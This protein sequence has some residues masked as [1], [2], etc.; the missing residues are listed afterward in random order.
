MKNQILLLA[1][2]I[3]TGTGFYGKSA[4]GQANTNLS[5]L[6]ATTSVN[7]NLLPQTNNTK[8]LGSTAYSWMNVY[9]DGTIF[10]GDAPFIT[11]IGS[12]NSL[13][14]N[15]AG[16]SITTG[17]FNTFTGDNAGRYTNT[18]YSNSFFGNYAG[19]SN[20]A[21]Y[22]NTFVGKSAGYLNNASFNTGV[23]ASALLNNTTG[24]NNAAVGFN[25]LASNTT[26]HKNTAMG[27]LALENNQQGDAN[28]A[29]GYSALEN[30]TWGFDN[31]AVGGHTLQNQVFAYGN[32]A[33]GYYALQWLEDGNGNTAIGSHAMVYTAS[34]AGCT[35]IGSYALATSDGN[36][37]TAIGTNA[38]DFDQTGFANTALGSGADVTGISLSNA[39]A[40]GYSAQVDASNKV[41]IGNSSVT[42]NGG[43]VSW[44]AYSDGRIKSSIQENV[45]GLQFINQLRPVTYHFDLN[46]QNELLGLKDTTQW[47]GKYDI[48]KIQ[49]TGFIAQEV[50]AAANKI[51]YD[52]SGVD[53]SGEIMG[54]RYA[55]FVVPLVKSV[56][57]LSEQNSILQT[58][59]TN[60]ETR[61]AKLEALLS[62]INT[63]TFQDA[64]GQSVKIL[65]QDFSL[66]QNIPNPYTGKTSINYFVPENAKQA[67]IVFATQGGIEVYSTDI[68]IGAGVVDID[69]TQLAPGNYVYC[70]FI[71]GILMGSKQMV[72]VK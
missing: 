30:N 65:N 56:Q 39:T 41:R 4:F 14:G 61:I 31:T 35:A 32:S 21:G 38:L 19:Y 43:Q 50:E 67:K 66:S 60:L 16:N 9:L 28:T 15:Y 51:D 46:K 42:S 34:A 62:E 20:T 45:P 10:I 11:K 69:A 13:I 47:E 54:L 22:L 2:L 55:E 5:N 36:N 3:I 23:G 52:F 44:T 17:A 33:L 1:L 71:D 26:G 72:L 6:A 24:E 40:I 63:N 53:K 68:Q 25:A 18:G 49:W 7:S 29:V 48:E 70:L 58:T 8:N 57:E 27:T 37:H 59:N 64:N 12:G